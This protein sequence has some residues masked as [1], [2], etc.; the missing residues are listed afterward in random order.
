MTDTHPH[1]HSRYQKLWET[2]E[3]IYTHFSL[4]A[5]SPSFFP[6][7]EKY[8]GAWVTKRGAVIILFSLSFILSSAQSNEGTRFWM[9]FMEKFET[10]EEE[11]VLMITS[12][13]STQGTVSIPGLNWAETFQVAAQEVSLVSI[14]FEAVPR[15]SENVTQTGILIES[16]DPVVVYAHQYEQFRAEASVI[17]PVSSLGNEYRAMTYTGYT[18]DTLGVVD[19][20]PTEFLVV[21]TENNTA[22]E[23]QVTGPT[24]GGLLIG[25]VRQ[26]ILNEGESYQV[27][28]VFGAASDLTGS[29]IRADKPIAVFSGNYWTQVPNGC[30]ARDNLYEQVYPTQS[31][32]RQFAIIPQ[33]KTSSTAIRVLAHQ[34]NTQVTIQGQVNQT[35]NLGQGQFSEF[36]LSGSAFLSSN[37]PVLV[38]QFSKGRDC[39]GH[40]SGIGDPAMVVLNSIEQTRDSVTLFASTF[41]NIEENF[42]NITARTQDVSTVTLD[43]TPVE[44]IEPFQAVQGNP[45][46]SFSQVQVSPGSH[47]LAS[48]GCGV[49]ATIYGYGEAESYAY[50]AGANFPTLNPDMLR[51]ITGGCV[52][53][54]LVFESG[55]SPLVF[56][57]NWDFG[58]GTTS[59]LPVPTHVYDA[60]GS[61]T[62]N[63]TVENIC[64]NTL[65]SYQQPLEISTKPQIQAG[66][67][68]SFCSLQPLVLSASLVSNAT[69]AWSGPNNF[70]STDR[71]PIIPEMQPQMGG[72]YEVRATLNGCESLPAQTQVILWDLPEPNLGNDT[73]LCEG[74]LF[75]RGPGPFPSYLWQDGSQGASFTFLQPGNYWVGVSDSLGCFQTDSLLIGEGCPVFVF[76]PSAFSPNG[77]GIN[78]V[79]EIVGDEFQSFRFDLYDRWGSQ[80]LS[81]D[82]PTLGWEGKLKNGRPAPEGVYTWQLI[83]S[84]LSDQGK[85]FTQKRFGTLTLIR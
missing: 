48:D 65:E 68:T 11:R 50:A 14:P 37:Q 28:S 29:L 23:I 76:V 74:E 75:E 18:R 43:G 73:V 58:D 66:N 54:S 60:E 9:G 35:L 69:Y 42:I 36:D 70:S 44:S 67:D 62:V 16:Q 72:T 3:V 1:I 84:G 30:N 55:L 40:P 52:G 12:K 49:A 27:Q 4:L 63:L 57:F 64:L 19:E 80:I 7:N 31:W 59:T 47:N 51:E 46:Y 79:F 85:V 81:L 25:D 83:F 78:D 10:G 17:L 8:K 33:Q 22:I 82:N 38:A 77:D 45:D 53:D 61:Y 39:N 32:G 6:L 5:S 13:F 41:R 34:D 20:F 56:S 15:G 71:L 24:L 21:A 26:L 2:L